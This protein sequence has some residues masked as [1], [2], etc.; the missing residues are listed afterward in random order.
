MNIEEKKMNLL[1]YLF[2]Y[3]IMI[4]NMYNIDES[5]SIKHSMDVY[6]YANEIYESE[7]IKNPYIKEHKTIID[8]SAIL[9]DMCDKKYMDEKVGLGYLETYMKYKITDN[10]LDIFLKIISTMS[11]ST[12]KKNGFPE[13]NEYQLAYNI[14]READLL[15]SYD[16][17]RCII[18]NMLKEKNSYSNAFLDATNL[19]EKRVFKYNDD[20]LFLTD[21]GIKLS[22]ELH[23]NSIKRIKFLS[24]IKKN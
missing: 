8:V 24:N 5:H 21:H 16:F 19:F 1:N 2:N 12:V 23:L 13:L 18:Y 3:V 22:K 4:S 6:Y 9:H 20:K 7:L 10:E 11:Y 17:E 15:A 14:V